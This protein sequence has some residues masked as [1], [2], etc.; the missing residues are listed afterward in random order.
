MTLANTDKIINH[1][2][3][4]DIAAAIGD[5]AGNAADIGDLTELTTTDRTDLVSAINEVDADAGSALTTIGTGSLNT[6]AQTLIPAV[7][8]LNNGKAQKS[9]LSSIFETGST[10]SQAIVSGT[11]FYLDGVLSRAKADIASGDTFTLNTNYEAV[12]AGGLNE[13]NSTNNVIADGA[14]AH[15]AIYRGKN[16]GTSVTADQYAAIA[17]GTFHDLF[18]GDYWVINSV[19]WRIAHFNY[20]YN[21]GD[22]ACETN[23]VV[24]VPDSNLTS[25]KM[26]STNITTGAYIGSDYYTGSNSNTGK[27]TAQTAIN[28]AFGAA[29]ILSHREYLKNAVTN[30]YESAGAW[31]DS[32]FE[33]MTEEMVYGTKE[34][35]NIINGTN[36]PA[37]YTIDHGQLALFRHDH[38]RICNH[39]TWWLRDVVSSATFAY[40][41]HHGICNYSSASYAFGV[42]PAFGITA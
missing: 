5:I 26:N 7:N 36:I 38:S 34:F 21:C 3:G 35:K 13:L 39:A 37:N 40:V 29:H 15:N 19:T 22:T 31:Y 14:G 10:A 32:T 4:I 33:L 12:T 27:A 8:E 17:A 6:T 24:I 28:N 9:D 18:I 42:R 23:H 25:A 16:L 2:D 30:G 1:Q 41:S 20:W 11:Y